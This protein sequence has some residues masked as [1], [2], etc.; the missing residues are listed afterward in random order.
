VD[1]ES[2]W[3]SSGGVQYAADFGRDV[4]AGEV[5][6]GGKC[7]ASKKEQISDKDGCK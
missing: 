7:L 5:H 4:D 1:H 2:V 6:A 3:E